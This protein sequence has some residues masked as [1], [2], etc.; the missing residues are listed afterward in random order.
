MGGEPI[1]QVYNTYGFDDYSSFYRAFKKEYNMSPKQL[2]QQ[3]KINTADAL[4]E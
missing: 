2:I 1:S 3:A 4:H